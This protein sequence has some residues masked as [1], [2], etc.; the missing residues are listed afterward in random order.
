MQLALISPAV[1]EAFEAF[2]VAATYTP[3]SGSPVA[4]RA[5]RMRQDPRSG[6]VSSPGWLIQLLAAEVATKPTEGA[7]VLLV[8]VTHRVRAVREGP[9][10]LSWLCDVDEVIP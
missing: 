3:L 4:V 2:G 6:Q 5:I 1:A 10:R 8:G 7:T 9:Q